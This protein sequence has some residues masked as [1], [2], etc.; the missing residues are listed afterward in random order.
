MVC[1]RKNRKSSRKSS[2]KHRKSSRKMNMRRM[3]YFGGADMEYNPMKL[4]L[5]QGQQYQ[6]LHKNQ[7][8]GLNMHKNANMEGGSSSQMAHGAPVGYD[9]MLP[10]DLRASARVEPTFSA[11]QQIQG[12]SDMPQ[13]T[14]TQQTGGRRRKSKSKKSKKSKKSR[15]GSRKSRKGSRKSRKGSR[16]SRK[17]S[18]KSRKSY[19]KMRGG[20][21]PINSPTMLLSPAMATKA[22][23]A[24]FSNPLLKY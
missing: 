16:K 3:N 1:S 6:E 23:T 21:A 2:R 11:M 22:G 15:K 20:M 18:R 19:R 10:T 9:G 24:D 8:G 7:H 12:M 13:A 4:S 14:T 5:A 17:G